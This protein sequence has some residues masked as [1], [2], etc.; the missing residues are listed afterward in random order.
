MIQTV[1][2]AA[3]WPEQHCAQK[4][5]KASAPKPGPEGPTIADRL[6]VSF[7]REIE[8]TR[9]LKVARIENSECGKTLHFGRFQKPFQLANARRMAHFS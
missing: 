1:V 4:K 2:N 8:Q 5:A 6:R 3:E 9:G 7:P